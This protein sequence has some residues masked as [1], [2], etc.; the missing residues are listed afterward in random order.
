MH[1]RLVAVRPGTVDPAGLEVLERAEC[2]RLLAL[3]G[4][5]RV[6][7]PAEPP[8]VRPVNF[9]L[10]GE[11]VV[12]RTGPGSLWRSA[13]EHRLVTF[14]IDGARNVDHRGWSVLATGA[15]MHL[16]PDDHALG[17]AVA[18]V[19][20]PRSRPVRR[21]HH[22]EVERPPADGT[23]MMKRA[24]ED[25]DAWG[26]SERFRRMVRR[27]TAPAYEHWFR[28][29]LDGLERV[30][31]TGGALL[32]ANHAG[33]LPVDAALL[34]H[35]IEVATGRAV[36]GLHHWMLR[37]APFVGTFLARNGGVVA[38]PPN[39]QRLLADEGQLV[40]VF[41]EG[42]KGTTKPWSQRYQLQRFGRGGF[43]E[44]AM[45]AGVPVL[46]VAVTGTEETMPALF[47]IEPRRGL[48]IPVTANAILFGP[49]GALVPWP[50][51]VA[52]HVLPPVALDVPVGLDT[53]DRRV[54]A[55]MAD[56]VRVRLQDELDRRVRP[57]DAPKAA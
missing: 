12:I 53:Y 2:L 5:G 43:I 39:A 10:D 51:K 1:R 33:A 40:L 57:G 44:V 56:V 27:L 22:R 48:R 34:M 3:G 4:V 49:A 26:R 28:V 55:E 37:E 17:T 30:P 47:T 42:T 50:V 16:D 14:E 31:R 32:V 23:T 13:S 25:Q 20:T 52:A 15:L 36:Y 24:I 6:A 29:E 19:G 46:P 54:V 18:G 35:G 8:L 45:R 11:R 38:N 9:V 41:P 21:D 7:L